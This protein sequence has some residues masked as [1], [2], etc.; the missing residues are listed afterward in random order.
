M[1]NKKIN[2][3]S[4]QGGVSVIS[5]CD[6]FFSFMLV[7]ACLLEVTILSIDWVCVFVCLCSVCKCVCVGRRGEVN[8]H[9]GDFC[10]VI[11]KFYWKYWDRGTSGNTHMERHGMRCVCVC[12]CMGVC[13]WV[14]M[15][16]CMFVRVCASVWCF[17]VFSADEIGPI[18]NI[19]RHCRC[20]HD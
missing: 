10:V 19:R 6:L 11:V 15:H 12:T 20:T 13:V 2:G 3:C 16:A 9:T 14:C 5:V 4:E 17:P 8:S 1:V 7:C 18:L